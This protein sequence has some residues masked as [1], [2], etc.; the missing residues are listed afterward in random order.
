M[1][2]H[3]AEISVTVAPGANAVLLL[4][5]ADWRGSVAVIVPSNIMLLPLTSKRPKLSPVENIWQ[6]MRDNWLSNRILESYSVILDH[7]C[8]A[9]NRLVEQTWHYPYQLTKMG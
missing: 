4:D 8:F 9:W 2:L 1:T 7:C 5:Q 6:V 3:L